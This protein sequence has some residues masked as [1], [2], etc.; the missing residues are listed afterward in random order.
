VVGVAQA[1]LHNQDD[2][3]EL[4]QETFVR[5]FQNLPKFE[6]RSSFSTWA[7]LDRRQFAIDFRRYEDRHPL[8]HGEEDKTELRRLPS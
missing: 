5:A 7:L 3:V 8:L 6:S 1:V 4:A 2:A